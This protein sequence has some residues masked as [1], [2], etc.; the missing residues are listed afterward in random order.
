MMFPPEQLELMV[1]YTNTRLDTEN[2]K[3]ITK[4]ELLEFFGLIILMTQFEFQLRASLWSQE[5]NS[6]YEVAPELGRSG[7]SRKRFDDIWTAL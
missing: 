5:A 4:G 7:M 1:Q 6:D 3:T 2:K